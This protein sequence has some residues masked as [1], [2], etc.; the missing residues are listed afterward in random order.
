MGYVDRTGKEVMSD[1]Q[2][3]GFIEVARG[4]NKI[5]ITNYEEVLW[6]NPEGDR[7]ISLCINPQSSYL[8]IYKISGMKDKLLERRPISIG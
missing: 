3:K 2:L 6:V 4:L 1:R 7:M 5:G 8:E